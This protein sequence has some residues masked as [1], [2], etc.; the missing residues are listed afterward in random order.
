MTAEQGATQTL[1]SESHATAAPA[2]GGASEFATIYAKVLTDLRLLD[3][4]DQLSRLWFERRCGELTDQVIE[5]L[6]REGLLRVIREADGELKYVRGEATAS[7]PTAP[8]AT[9]VKANG[10][11]PVVVSTKSSSTASRQRTITDAFRRD[12]LRLS[13][14]TI[15]TIQRIQHAFSATEN[16]A[17]TAAGS[18]VRE[19]ILESAGLSTWARPLLI[20]KRV[21]EKDVKEKP[22]TA[23]VQ[24]QKTVVPS[25]PKPAQPLVAKH[26][27]PP[28]VA[29]PPAT[30]S[31]EDVE[32]TARRLLPDARAWVVNFD[33]RKII[34]SSHLA[35]HFSVTMDVANALYRLLQE[36]GLILPNRH[37]RTRRPLRT[38][39]TRSTE[40]SSHQ[41]KSSG[42]PRR[43]ETVED[44]LEQRRI[45]LEEVRRINLRLNTLR[46]SAQRNRYS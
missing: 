1:T 39:A 29:S 5:K 40:L 2:T 24:N 8:A 17:R 28:A 10:S 9:P 35:S 38:V 13:R 25:S 16:E 31:T 20:I 45:F 21:E 26:S 12:A 23:P 32:V 4:A 46:R 30:S 37:I 36:E 27:N 7:R 22:Q 44:L 43:K 15:W 42:Q 14:S 33:G 6:L 19:G 41:S 11:R 34:M 3:R 18:L